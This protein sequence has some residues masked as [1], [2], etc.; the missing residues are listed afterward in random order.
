MESLDDAGVYK[1]TEELA[2]IQTVDFFTPIV[3]DPYAFGQI[4]AA[5]ALSDVYT[6]GGRPLTA[7]NIV[8][9]P[10][11]SLD[12][13]VLKAILKG[14]V[15]KM[16]EAGV[17]LLGGHSVDDAELKYGL[18]VTGM[19]HPNRLI[20][21]SGAK[22]GD[23]LV[24]TKPLGTGIIST[25]IKAGEA[26]NRTTAKVVRSM[27]AL[28]KHA[29]EVMQEIGVH[30]CTDITG[31]GFIGHACQLAQ[32]SHVGLMIDAVNVP[33]FEE[34]RD[35]INKGLC[36]GGL[37]RNRD[38]YGS[39]VEFGRNV[40]EYLKDVLFDPQTSGG[41]LIALAAESAVALLG[42]LS[43]LGVKEAAIVGEVIEEP[44]GRM[45]VS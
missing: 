3:D 12:I 21:N 36:P 42:R 45:L 1:L 25:A 26:D 10:S 6:M 15:D 2:I 5:N 19:V 14:G 38:F 41:L 34:V 13:S 18:A 37:Y 27:A 43:E 33:V 11:K 24:L 20:T 17:I 44:E 31:F 29:C 8:C 39:K 16:R 4:A 23:K 32:N 35:F 7:L 9:F 28:N 22:P 40:P 30:A